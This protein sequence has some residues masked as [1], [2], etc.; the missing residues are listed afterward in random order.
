MISRF[1]SLAYLD[2]IMNGIMFSSML[3]GCIAYI[4]PETI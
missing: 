2:D 3:S 4:T 1:S